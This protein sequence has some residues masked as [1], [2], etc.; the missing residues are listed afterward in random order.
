MTTKAQWTEKKETDI[1]DISFA[2]E[3]KRKLEISSTSSVLANSQ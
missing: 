2:Q 1:F 3:N